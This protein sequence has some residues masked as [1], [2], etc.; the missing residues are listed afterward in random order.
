M[1]LLERALVSGFDPSEQWVAE[2]LQEGEEKVHAPATR[3][4]CREVMH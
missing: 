4:V 3:P 1:I 2:A